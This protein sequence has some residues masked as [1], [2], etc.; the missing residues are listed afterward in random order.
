MAHRTREHPDAAL[1]DLYAVPAGSAEEVTDV[2]KLIWLGLAGGAGA[3]SRYGLAG[4]VHR[5]AGGAF[6]AGTFVVNMAGCLLFGLVWGVLEDR[7]A[8]P[9]QVRVVVLTG[10]MGA[11]TTFSTYVFESASLLRD[12]QWAYALVNMA[13]QNLAGLALLFAGLALARYVP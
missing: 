2:D 12:G 13:G 5:V 8:L 9:P 4:L 3:L 1:R 10:F 11:F 6:P 7:A